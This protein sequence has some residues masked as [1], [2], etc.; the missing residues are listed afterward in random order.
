MSV[1]SG[2]GLVI[3]LMFNL[4]WRYSTGNN[5]LIDPQADLKIVQTISRAYAVGPILYLLAFGL[6]FVMVSAS[7]GLTI[8]LAIF[9]ALPNSAVR[10]LTRL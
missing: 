6:S 5:R 9:F 1:Y 2:W 7:L 10:K 8:A 4:V 3:A